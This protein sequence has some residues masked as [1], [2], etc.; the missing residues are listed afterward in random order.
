VVP[1]VQCLDGYRSLA[2]VYWLAWQG[3]AAGDAG[4]R[5]RRRALRA[6][7]D[8]AFFARLFPIAAPAALRARARFDWSEGRSPHALRRWRRSAA[9]A[10]R[11]AMPYDEALASLDLA[12][13]ADAEGERARHAERARRL[14]AEL[15]CRD[16]SLHRGIAR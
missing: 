2:D 10:R 3:V 15:G 5:L 9:A 13:A 14:F 12:Q 4:S 7:R 11:L 6:T 16:V 8:L 1:L